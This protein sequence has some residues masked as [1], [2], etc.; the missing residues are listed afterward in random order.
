MEAESMLIIMTGKHKD[1]MSERYLINLMEAVIPKYIS[2]TDY[3][4]IMNSH[5]SYIL[6]GELFIN[7]DKVLLMRCCLQ[8][9]KKHLVNSTVT[10]LDTTASD[11]NLKYSILKSYAGV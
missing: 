3:G 10:V 1:I 5:V 2:I 4:I 7:S 8:Y 6:F 11:N 9:L